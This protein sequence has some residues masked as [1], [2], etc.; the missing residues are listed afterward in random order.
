MA[1]R[2]Y[3][4]CPLSGHESSCLKNK[5]NSSMKATISFGNP[6][7]GTAFTVAVLLIGWWIGARR[8]TV[9]PIQEY[10]AC[11]PGT[12]TQESRKVG[13]GDLMAE[14]QRLLHTWSVRA[15]SIADA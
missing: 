2:D 10:H 12:A 9:F 7:A 13:E 11:T 4:A 1:T 15:E 3:S 5:D 14:P 6:V 8:D